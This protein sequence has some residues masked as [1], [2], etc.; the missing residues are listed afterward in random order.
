MCMTTQKHTL[1]EYIYRN[2][3]GRINNW[4]KTTSP[5]IFKQDLQHLQNCFYKKLLDDTN[6]SR[7]KGSIVINLLTDNRLFL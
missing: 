7:R 2:K 4:L 1:T 5:F 3:L 6:S